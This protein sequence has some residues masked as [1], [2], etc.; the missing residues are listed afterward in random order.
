[1][2]IFGSGSIVST[3]AQSGLIDDYRIFINPIVLEAEASFKGRRKAQA[4][5][6]PRLSMR[7]SLLHWAETK[8]RNQA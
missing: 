2:V 4:K 7:G 3:F 8:R 5:L 6:T 1:M